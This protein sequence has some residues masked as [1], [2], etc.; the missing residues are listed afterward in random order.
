MAA[1]FITLSVRYRIRFFIDNGKLMV[2][3]TSWVVGDRKNN[4]TT[5]HEVTPELFSEFPLSTPE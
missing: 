4:Q 1:A 5:V 3:I 2:R